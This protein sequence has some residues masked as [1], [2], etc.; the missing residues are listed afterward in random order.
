[1]RG[2]LLIYVLGLLAIGGYVAAP[3]VTAWSIREAIRS[4]DASYLEARVDWPRVKQSL[5]VSMAD[6]AL[7]SAGGP[8]GGPAGAVNSPNHADATQSPAPGLWQRF[9]NA[10]GR[11]VIASMIDNMVTP[12]GL[13]RLFS[14]RQGYN[15]KI[16][17]IPDERETLPL[18]ERIGRSWQRV[19]RAEFLSPS[20][21]AMEMRDKVVQ[22]RTYAG[23]LEL[24]GM[25]WR[26]V[27]LAVKRDRTAGP[28]FDAAKAVDTAG[29]S[30]WSKLRQ[31]ALAPAR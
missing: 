16:R 14:Y 30:L 1:M 31:A 3:F 4:G 25:Q 12:A 23:I 18:H 24:Q 6:Y 27:H 11:R 21:F 7:G 2:K 13:A 17:G 15:E 10:Y 8:A 19:V 29:P 22:D 26:L 5:K 9:K 20:R 28:V